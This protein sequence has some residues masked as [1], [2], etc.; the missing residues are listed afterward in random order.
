MLAQIERSDRWLDGHPSTHYFRALTNCKKRSGL[1]LFCVACVQIAAGR[2]LLE[3]FAISAARG[4]FVADTVHQMESSHPSV[5][6]EMLAHAAFMFVVGPNGTARSA[7]S[8][9]VHWKPRLASAQITEA[10]PERNW[11]FPSAAASVISS[12]DVAIT[13][14]QPYCAELPATVLEIVAAE[15][16]SAIGHFS[17]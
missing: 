5:V 15:P 9:K 14:G 10:F 4:T 3:H 1:D 2:S 8:G 12:A 17:D 6:V 7:G 13:F 16:S 11:G